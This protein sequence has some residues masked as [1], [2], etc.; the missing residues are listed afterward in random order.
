MNTFDEIELLV[1]GIIAGVIGG[2][3]ISSDAYVSGVAS[4]IALTLLCTAFS[5]AWVGIAELAKW[6]FGKVLGGRKC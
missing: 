5:V 3:I 2:V 6:I 4:T 1:A